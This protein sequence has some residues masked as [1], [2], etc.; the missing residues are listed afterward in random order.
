PEDLR[1]SGDEENT[2]H[3]VLTAYRAGD[4]LGALAS[5]PERAAARSSGVVCFHAALRLAVGDVTQAQSAID[6]VP[7]DFAPAMAIQELITAVK[8]SSVNTATPQTSSELLARS[9]LLQSRADL[10]GARDAARR[11][12][13]RTPDLG[14]AHARLAELEFSFGQRRAALAELERALTL[15][16]RLANGYAIRGFVLLE[17]S[18]DAEAL[19]AFERARELDAAFG[20]AWLGRGLCLL[21]LNKYSEARAAFQAAAALE[22]QRA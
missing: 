21:R 7:S 11:A 22:P 6:T 8:G 3:A 1:L 17:P 4:M 13:E 15:S 9:Y 10:D 14:I 19:A 5:W 2:L 16:P 20:P 12:V 18:R